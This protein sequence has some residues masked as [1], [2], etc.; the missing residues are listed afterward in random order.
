MTS[1][2]Q[3]MGEA[4]RSARLAQPPSQH[5]L[6]AAVAISRTTL[7]Q[8]EKGE[9]AQ[10]PNVELTAKALGVAFGI[11]SELAEMARR[12]TAHRTNLSSWAVCRH[13]AWPVTAY[14][15]A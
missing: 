13:W 12:R 15:R 6:A 10:M 8:I 4:L 5:A 2:R 1:F 7:I 14:R 11:L 3:N 9:D